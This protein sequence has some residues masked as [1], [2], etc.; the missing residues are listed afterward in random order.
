MQS[1][2]V[3]WLV[4]QV[5]QAQELI[6]QEFL[7]AS[8]GAPAGLVPKVLAVNFDLRSKLTGPLLA[9]A[10]YQQPDQ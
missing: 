8:L 6:S 3:V 5:D 1:E 2:A 9:L 4:V 7:L 10:W